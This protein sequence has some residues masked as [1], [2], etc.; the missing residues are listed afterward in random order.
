VAKAAQAFYQTLARDGTTEAFR[1][2]MFDF[3]AL[4]AIIGT[5]QMLQLGRSYEF[6]PASRG[7]ETT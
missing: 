7:E 2:D 4:N 6:G 3:D 1:G 5:P